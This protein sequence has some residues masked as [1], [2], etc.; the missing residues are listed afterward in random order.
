MK[1]LLVKLEGLID[2]QSN[3]VR[4]LLFIP[5]SLIIST[6]S[7]LLLYV[8]FSLLNTITMWL[9]LSILTQLVSLYIS[10]AVFI[11][12]CIRIVPSHKA[13]TAIVMNT[14]ITVFSVLIII[15]TIVTYITLNTPVSVY[16][17]AVIGVACCAIGGWSGLHIQKDYIKNEK[18]KSEDIKENAQE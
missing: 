9:D 17:W 6:V 3:V 11:F 15:I 16:I 18:W 7:A 10:F 14:I 4:W 8:G 5:E 1:N 12:S 13:G 2:K